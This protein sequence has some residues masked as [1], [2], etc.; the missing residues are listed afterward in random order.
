[1]QEQIFDALRRGAHDDALA[2]ARSAVDAEP[3]SAQPR[4]WLAMALKAAGR[5]DEAIAALDH[6]IALAPEDANLHLHRAG[7]LLGTR[8][9]ASAQSAL[10]QAVSLDPNQFPAYIL[11]ANLAL[12]EGR[13]DE[14]ERLSRLAA[15]VAPEH[16]WGLS[17]EAMIALHRGDADGALASASRALEA[18][19]DDPRVLLAGGLA[20]RQ[21]GHHAFAE[22]T[23]RTLLDG[24]GGSAGVRLMLVQSL[25]AQNRADE[26]LEALQPL[27]SEATVPPTLLRL[28]GELGLQ[29]GRRD[30]AL[31]WLRV[32][33]QQMPDDERT[34]TALMLA[35]RMAGDAEDA[36]RTLEEAIADAPASAALW[37]ARLAVATDEAQADEIVD[38]W[39]AAMP[40]DVAA[41]EVRMQQQYRRGELEAAVATAHRILETMP[42]NA[43][44]HGLVVERLAAR[45]P[46]AAVAHVESLLPQARSDAS[47]EWVLGW[48]AAL[49]D[50]AGMQAGAVA[51]WTTLAQLRRE[52]QLPLPPVSLPPEQVPAGPWPAWDAGAGDET[53]ALRTL[54]LW[55][56]PGSCVENVAAQLASF[57]GFRGDRLSPAAPGDGFQRFSSVEQLSSGELSAAAVAEEWRKGLAARGIEGEHVIEWL[58]WWDNALLR[59]LRA[60]VADAGLL[61]VVRDPRDMLLQ[62][63]ACGSPMQFALP[64]P[65]M[66]AQWLAVVLSQ[67]LA[68]AGEPLFRCAVM[69]LDGIE[70]DAEA[71]GARLS[72]TLRSEVPIAPLPT[73][74]LP[75]GHWRHYSEALAEPFAALTPIAK[76]LGYPET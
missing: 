13:L 72:E 32:A 31:A 38:R 69:K 4:L 34:V 39:N 68:V 19:P 44:A 11:Q 23:F 58:V 7:L 48:L 47:K 61:F 66:A 63:L 10:E 64:S 52:R 12:A 14:A 20:Y 22:Q 62:W 21:K 42:G 76:V 9:L 25:Q 40:D 33:L 26:A 37:R 16:P 51:N 43:M 29:T 15:R 3:Q 27:L 55:G 24:E 59:V 70:G 50:K 71:I 5:Q 17:L 35:W 75:A 56:P 1:M 57:G 41:L 74:S 45:D 49:Q 6:G 30:D 67:M 46:E 36:R 60:Q 8:D 2:L 73:A 54:F 53:R 28:A 18:A 65:L